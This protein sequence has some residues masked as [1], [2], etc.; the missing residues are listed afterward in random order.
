MARVPSMCFAAF[1]KILAIL[2]AQYTEGQKTTEKKWREFRLCT[3][4][5]L[6]Q[7]WPHSTQQH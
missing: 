2:A 1:A 3:L 5:L 4:L 7:F 6:L